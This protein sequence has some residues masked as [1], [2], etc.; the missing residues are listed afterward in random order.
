MNARALNALAGVICRAQE[1]GKQTPMGLA[2]AVESAGLLLSPESAAELEELREQLV[3]SGD[4]GAE[5][6][7]RAGENGAA[8]IELRLEN[9]RLRERANAAPAALSAEQRAALAENLG[10]AKP[11]T[12]GLLVSFAETIRECREHDHGSQRED[13]FC[14]NL[15][16]YM[17]ERMA[18]VLRR[19]LDAEARVAELE[20]APALP[21][22]AQMSDGDLHGFLDDLV[23]AA[24]NRWRSE[25]DVPDRETLAAIEKACAEWRTPGQGFRSDDEAVAS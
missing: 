3:R 9:E 12:D 23:S 14:L 6:F 25:P 5:A 21:W 10:D 20:A 22:A 4:A 2:I 7:Q 8:A 24:M 13:W 15:S 16:S 18:P 17:G 1:N 19:L 11:A